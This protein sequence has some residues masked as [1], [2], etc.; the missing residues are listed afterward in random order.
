MVK[1][2]HAPS[3][4]TGSWPGTSDRPGARWNWL[5]FWLLVRS[6]VVPGILL[7]PSILWGFV[8]HAHIHRYIHTYKQADILC[9]ITCVTL[10]S[11]WLSNIHCLRM[12]T[13]DYVDTFDIIWFCLILILIPFGV[14]PVVNP[15]CRLRHANK[16]FRN[17]KIPMPNVLRCAR[18]AG[19]STS[20][21]SWWLWVMT[22]SP[23][24]RKLL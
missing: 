4:A 15:P 9:C 3:A 18:A 23:L 14:C 19:G 5:D 2:P 24:G 11:S 16:I 10:C 17:W 7:Y 21:H 20:C 12:F 13:A 1:T 22:P 6:V 8:C